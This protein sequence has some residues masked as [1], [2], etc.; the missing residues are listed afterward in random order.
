[1]LVVSDGADTKFR[2]GMATSSDFQRPGGVSNLV[3]NLK[4]FAD[5]SGRLVPPEE[6]QCED[7]KCV[8]IDRSFS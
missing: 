2:P 8:K 4:R 6:V 3:A 7:V 5:V 1:M